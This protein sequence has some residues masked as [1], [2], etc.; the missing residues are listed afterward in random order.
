MDERDMTEYF[1]LLLLGGYGLVLFVVA[2]LWDAKQHQR[3]VADAH[4][5]VPGGGGTPYRLAKG[6][7]LRQDA[8]DLVEKAKE[9]VNQ[10]KEQLSAVLEA[11]KR[12]YDAGHYDA[13]EQERH[14]KQK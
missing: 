6:L 7:E 11:G 10:Q 12:A 14:G 13:K 8:A 2:L 9:V 1:S 3:H 4:G 5:T